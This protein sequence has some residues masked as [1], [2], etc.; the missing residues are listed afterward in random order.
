[1]EMPAEPDRPPVDAAS[2]E[3]PGA[4]PPGQ[5]PPIGAPPPGAIDPEN[6]R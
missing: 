4:P 6:R 2:D 1:M 3:P 5:T